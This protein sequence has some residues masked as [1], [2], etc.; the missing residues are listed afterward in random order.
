MARL[1]L[2]WGVAKK[3][4]AHVTPRLAVRDNEALLTMTLDGLGVALLPAWMTFE[5]VSAG[6]LVPILPNFCGPSVDLNIVFSRAEAWRQTF[7]HL[8]SS[9]NKGSNRTVRGNPSLSRNF[10]LRDNANDRAP[11]HA[12]VQHT[13]IHAH[14]DSWFYARAQRTKSNARPSSGR[15]SASMRRRG[16]VN[17]LR[18][19]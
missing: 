17:S 13:V 4:W 5:H 1:I 19:R 16:S 9:S 15:V 8:W 7:A 12:Q 6:L 3:N 10:S 11:T 14:C 18:R 2:P